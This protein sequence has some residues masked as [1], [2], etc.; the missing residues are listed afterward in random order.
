[1]DSFRS[2][3][4]ARLLR[5]VLFISL[6]PHF[7]AFVSSRIEFE[8]FD[9][10][11][12]TVLDESFDHS[13]AIRSRLFVS[14]GD[15]FECIEFR[16]QSTP[17]EWF[18]FD[19]AHEWNNIDA[20]HGVVSLVVRCRWNQRL[21][22]F[23]R[24][25]WFVSTIDDRLFFCLDVRSLF[26]SEFGSSIADHSSRS[27]RLCHWMDE[28]FSI[29]RQ[30][31]VECVRWSSSIFEWIVKVESFSS[32]LVDSQSESSWTNSFVSLPTNQSSRWRK[33]ATS[34]FKF[35][36][37]FVV[38]LIRSLVDGGVPPASVSISA[39]NAQSSPN[40]SSLF[41]RSAF[42]EFQKELNRQANLREYLIEHLMNLPVTK[43]WNT[44]QLQSKSLVEL[45]QSTNQLSRS[46]LVR[47]KAN[48]PLSSHLLVE[49]G[50][51]SMSRSGFF[52]VF[53]GATNSSRR[54]SN[55][56]E[57]ADPMFGK[58]S[59]GRCLFSRRWFFNRLFV[60]RQW[61]DLF[62]NEWLFWIPIESRR[63]ACPSI[64]K[65]I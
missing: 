22:S 56:I 30:S 41:N 45:T 47:I 53:D 36:F 24:F 25:E 62:N 12:T 1:M 39:L 34:R 42:E 3:Q 44:I 8:S 38:L 5:S 46:L 65:Q 57:S 7:V 2:N 59:N 48:I 32:T 51:S 55:C 20:L 58:S 4:S 52:V 29:D 33:S 13:V 40:V 60:F 19:L 9:R 6:L 31:R 61:M 10:W 64:T 17:S 23:H 16:D 54:S 15:K 21:F 14:L 63:F 26:T 18:L 49:F 35:V 50:V 28:S 37:F 43:S 11:S 27:T